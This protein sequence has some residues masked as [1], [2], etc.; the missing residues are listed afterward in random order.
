MAKANKSANL[1]GPEVQRLRNKLGLT[2]EEFAAQCQL[3]GLDISRGVLSQI[4]AR[5]R[6]VTDQELLILAQILKVSTDSL[7]PPE[8]RKRKRRLARAVRVGQS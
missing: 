5:I 2:Q 1:V 6:C 3:G 8:L 4:E 7:F